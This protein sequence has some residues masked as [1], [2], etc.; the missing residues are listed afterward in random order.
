MEDLVRPGRDDV[1]LGEHLD[2]VGQRME[3]PHHPPPV[4]AGAVGPDSVLDDGRLL[5][6]QPG[7]ERCQ[8][9]DAEEHERHHGQ[10]DGHVYHDAAVP[11]AASAS[12]QKLQ[13]RRAAPTVLPENRSFRSS[14]P[15]TERKASASPWKISCG[16]RHSQRVVQLPGQF[17]EHAPVFPGVC[18]RREGAPYALNSTVAVHEGPVL[19][20]V[21]CGGQNPVGTTR[22][23]DFR[24]C[25]RRRTDQACAKAARIVSSSNSFVR[26]CP[27]THNA[28]MRP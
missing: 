12:P 6:L 19:F 9:Q 11:A 24:W 25:L 13:R 26:S 27:K 3:Q 5:A 17:Q 20:H 14:S 16:F 28:S 4:D 23:W 18:Q 22:Q 21:R 7:V 15:R 1:L 10:L 2:G 8:V